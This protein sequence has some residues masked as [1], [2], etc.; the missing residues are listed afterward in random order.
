M[1]SRP[2]K[3]KRTPPSLCS[4]RA[5]VATLSRHIAAKAR[6]AF[7]HRRPRGASSP[8]G[9]RF[10]EAAYEIRFQRNGRTE[11]LVARGVV[12][13][14]P[15]YYSRASVGFLSAATRA[16]AFGNRLRRSGRGRC[17]Y[18]GRNR[19]GPR[20]TGLAF[21]CP[22]AKNA[23]RLARCGIRRCF[24]GGRPR[25]GC[26]ITSFVGGATEPEVLE[27]PDE[28]NCGARAG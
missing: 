27:K 12:M 13:A 3:G 23:A 7:V 2:E 5:G 24:P 14:T 16:H 19:S 8:H 9:R 4:F 6:R 11:T 25:G 28:R 15:A 18:Y 21:W 26:T 1:K 20:S 17:G 10:D 22:A